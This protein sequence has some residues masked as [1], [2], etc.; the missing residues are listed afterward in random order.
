L[1][2]TQEEGEEE[3][4]GDSKR[5]PWNPQLAKGEL[6]HGRLGSFSLP[7]LTVGWPSRTRQSS[8]L[9]TERGGGKLMK[10]LA[11]LMEHNSSPYNGS[12]EGNSIQTSTWTKMRLLINQVLGWIQQ[13]G[14]EREP[15]LEMLLNASSIRSWLQHLTGQRGIQQTT[16]TTYL[17]SLISIL[18]GLQAMGLGGMCSRAARCLIKDLCCVRRQV[19][20]RASITSSHKV[21]LRS[22]GIMQAM[23]EGDI[24]Q[25]AEQPGALQYGLAMEHST[26]MASKWLEVRGGRVD[27]GMGHF[28]THSTTHSLTP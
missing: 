12:R 18:Q 13:E 8:I 3:G 9:T 2:P 23:V 27:D 11:C 4:E 26:R 25:L 24:Q 22:R 14:D 28:L 20:K 10:Q 21:M 17:S 7:S 19:C 5:I 6:A 16:L 15:C 1:P